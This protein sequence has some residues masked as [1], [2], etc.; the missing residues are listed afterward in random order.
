MVDL[1]AHE[2]GN[3]GQGQGRPTA[4]AVLFYSESGVPIHRSRSCCGRE[5]IRKEKI[6]QVGVR[7]KEYTISQSKCCQCVGYLEAQK[8]TP[9]SRIVTVSPTKGS[10]T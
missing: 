3:G 6:L 9:S 7:R 2:A 1:C 5:L 4:Q 10:S 8:F